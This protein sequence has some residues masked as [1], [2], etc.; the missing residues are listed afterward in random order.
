MAN[1]LTEQTLRI[2][3][4]RVVLQETGESIPNLRL[5]AFDVSSLGEKSLRNKYL[6]T[7][8]DATW[9]TKGNSLGSSLSSQSGTFSIEYVVEVK[10][11]APLLALLVIAPEIDAENPVDHV[12]HVVPHLLH[13]VGL[14]EEFFISIPSRQLRANPEKKQSRL[15]T[16]IEASQKSSLEGYAIIKDVAIDQLKSQ[17][18]NHESYRQ[19]ISKA[20]RERAVRRF[21][22]ATNGKV[23][24]NYVTPTSS[25]NKTQHKAF[26]K[27]F[28]RV[29][30]V[31]LE[32]LVDLDDAA[33]TALL[34]NAG[35]P[36][37]NLLSAEI[38][39]ILYSEQRD[40]SLSN[41]SFFD[42][43]GLD[44]RRRRIMQ[45]IRSTNAEIPVD[46]TVDNQNGPD[47]PVTPDDVKIRLGKLLE[48]I[49]NAGRKG[50]NGESPSS[51]NGIN[52]FV[53]GLDLRGGA[54]DQ[55]AL[56]N[57]EKLNFAF[58]HV[59]QD[60]FDPE[61]EN[62]L[63]TEYAATDQVINFVEAPPNPSDNNLPI[64]IL[65]KLEYEAV[66]LKAVLSND[67][68]LGIPPETIAFGIPGLG[69]IRDAVGAIVDVVLPGNGSGN[70]SS[71][72]PDRQDPRSTA[73]P[74]DRQSGGRMKI[75]NTY[76]KALDREIARDYKF[77]VFGTDES[78]HAINYGV[79]TNYQQRWNPQNYQAGELVKTIPLAPEQSIKFSTKRTIKKTYSEK[80]AEATENAY[81]SEDQSTNRDISKIVRNAT[82]ETSFTLENKA[83]SSIPGVGGASSGSTFNTKFSNQSSRTKESFREQVRKEVHNFKNSTSI[84]IDSTESD[85][86]IEERSSEMKNPNSEISFTCLFYELQRR[87]L[88]S[89]RIHRITPV[90]LVAE[91]VWRPSE[92]TP[93]LIARYDWILR[94]VLLDRSFEDALEA[95]ASG[96]LV[97]EKAALADLEDLMEEQYRVVAE[98]RRQLS[99]TLER[100]Y[101][102]SIE[103]PLTIKD[104]FNSGEERTDQE[105]LDD[106]KERAENLE[107]DLRRQ[108]GILSATVDRFNQAFTT[109]AT[110]VIQVRRFQ[111]HIKEN[112]IYYMQA[113]WN[114]E[115]NH[116][117]LMRLRNLQVPKITGNIR[118]SLEQSG[119]GEEPPHWRAPFR[120]R[121]VAENFEVS[122]ENL[123]LAEVADLSR[124]LGFFGNYRVYP[125][126]E[127]NLVVEMLMVPY[128]SGHAGIRDPDSVGN[129][130]IADLEDYVQCLSETLTSEEY[131]A[132]R[133]SIEAAFE[134]R[135]SIA[136]ADQEE[137]VI[138]TGSLFI[139][140]LPG[141]HSAL[142]SFKR[143]HRA[144][145]VANAVGDVFTQKLEHLRMAARIAADQ[146]SD[147][148]I[149]KVVITNGEDLTFGDI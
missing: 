31:T 134:R 96:E 125:L 49:D 133:P 73:A 29:N 107:E 34:D 6:L 62:I 123:D 117:T 149:E 55:Q 15:K 18:D 102:Q 17:R 61:W 21:T 101:R 100:T 10:R 142:E 112:V 71:N 113:V 144:I 39:N 51:L 126:I 42:A 82:L 16:A 86:F 89:E 69:T 129:Y 72:R 68:P 41:W 1:K 35:V 22:N 93:E 84:E 23:P 11:N 38:R 85:E 46:E 130:T 5:H 14:R 80:R 105:A 109:Y 77:T 141:H 3:T 28:V 97:A 2:I 91:T 138:P 64:D 67:H 45:R 52:T 120:V 13:K 30:R 26:S 78:G 145:D 147:P 37:A 9:I 79:L 44:C 43:L 135:L 24:D 131:E 65:D 119:L 20:L 48:E 57:F 95:I 121:A 81:N 60:L 83:D 63:A 27:T 146:L 33:R 19:K 128:L 75:L 66:N 139:D 53:Y 108:D 54:A 114:H 103:R 104:I 122:D 12:I 74:P 32:A 132:L 88:V 90:I 56:F 148:D 98:L 136:R 92:I 106:L 70:G 87:Y 111:L 58:D 36:R 76:I 50:T 7:I 59:W 124:P 140:L 118:Y 143:Q 40:P 94:R 137:V 116:Q 47:Q 99:K 110:K 127:N 4:G 115:D 25:V 8:E